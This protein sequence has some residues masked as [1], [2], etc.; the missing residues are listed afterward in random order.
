MIGGKFLRGKPQAAQP[1]RHSR[2][3]PPN[4]PTVIELRTHQR[5]TIHQPNRDTPSGGVV[6][7]LLC[8]FTIGDNPQFV[9]QIL[10]FI[11]LRVRRGQQHVAVEN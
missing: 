6:A 8:L 5:L 3:L 9:K 7:R 11:F 10:V 4:H 2:K 1:P